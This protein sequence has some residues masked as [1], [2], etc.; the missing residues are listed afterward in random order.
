[1]RTATTY[2]Q[3]GASTSTNG[4]NSKRPRKRKC[5][6][7]GEEH[8][9]SDTEED[10]IVR[11][12]R[13][14][15]KSKTFCLSN[16]IQVDHNQNMLKLPNGINSVTVTRPG[17]GQPIRVKLP[18]TEPNQNWCTI[19]VNVPNH[20]VTCPKSDLA[21]N[22]KVLK[23]TVDLAKKEKNTVQIPI[24][25][26]GEVQSFGVYAVPGLGT[27]AFVGPF[28]SK[29]EEIS[30]NEDSSVGHFSE[31]KEFDENADD[32]EPS[33]NPMCPMPCQQ[34]G[35]SSSPSEDSDDAPTVEPA[36]F[37]D[38]TGR[39]ADLGE[40][41]QDRVTNLAAGRIRAYL[42]LLNNPTEAG[43]YRWGGVTLSR[44]EVEKRIAHL[45]TFQ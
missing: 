36:P 42:L 11:E 24:T 18:L 7:Q 6:G 21:L 27:H 4:H 34:H 8:H 44:S 33:C 20:T 1:V 45:G 35:A 9:D 19:R 28:T 15:D 38:G 23:K 43:D 10:G 12:A 29:Q 13:P 39:D 22:V 3:Y 37:N 5:D 41:Q 31:T 26:Q 16:E 32:S 2:G 14:M 30:D 17:P 25:T 40:A